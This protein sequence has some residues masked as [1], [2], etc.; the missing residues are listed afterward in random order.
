V[1]W[2]HVAV[3]LRPT[4]S[5]SA[6]QRGAGKDGKARHVLQA[7]KVDGG[8]RVGD[9]DGTKGGGVQGVTHRQAHIQ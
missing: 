1:S 9:R 4:L 3:E 7:S 5:V 8:I 2:Y 6:D